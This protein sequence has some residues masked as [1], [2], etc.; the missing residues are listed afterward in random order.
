MRKILRHLYFSLLGIRPYFSSTDLAAIDAAVAQSE[1]MHGCQ[2]SL[3][4]EG[5]MPLCD[6]FRGKS[7]RERAWEIFSLERLWDTERNVGVLMYL[8]L[9]DRKVEIVVDRGIAKVLD[10][11]TLE[12][13]CRNLETHFRK[14]NFKNGV[15]ELLESLSRSL[16]AHYPPNTG[17]DEIPRRVSIY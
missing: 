3:A 7:C 8:S 12:P 17:S 10:E 1:R 4:L 15:I 13:L 5:S 9:T 14:S 16:A 2:L 11:T 6:L